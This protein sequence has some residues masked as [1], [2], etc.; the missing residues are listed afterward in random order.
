MCIS[1]AA[2][3]CSNTLQDSRNLETPKCQLASVCGG[4][5]TAPPPPLLSPCDTAGRSRT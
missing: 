1:K 2:R 4:G 5:M 3:S